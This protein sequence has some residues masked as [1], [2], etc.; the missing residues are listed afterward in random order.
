MACLI[1]IRC[2]I[3]RWTR[4]KRPRT[5][6]RR[7]DS[8]WMRVW[9]DRVALAAQAS[10][11]IVAAKIECRRHATHPYRSTSRLTSRHP[12]IKLR[13]SLRRQWASCKRPRTR[14][15][16]TMT[17]VWK[18]CLTTAKCR[19]ATMTPWW[20]AE[21]KTWSTKAS[22]KS[23]KRWRGTSTSTAP[24]ANRRLLFQG[25]SQ[26]IWTSRIFRAPTT[27]WLFWPTMA[28]IW[29]CLWRQGLIPAP[30]H[31]T[32]MEIYPLRSAGRQIRFRLRRRKIARRDKLPS[33]WSSLI[34][35]QTTSPPSFRQ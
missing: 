18:R 22:C 17:M 16:T 35:V 28:S 23:I 15:W 4:S 13:P 6:I 5:A 34:C 8:L 20:R 11:Q 21:S 26:P 32:T 30:R 12:R 14:H 19:N 7:R 9:C 1:L 24:L 25:C 3:L 10:W 31:R 2:R 33:S 27:R 29:I